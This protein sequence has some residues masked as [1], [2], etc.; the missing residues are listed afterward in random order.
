MLRQCLPHTDKIYG[1][2]YDPKLLHLRII[3]LSFLQPL[4]IKFQDL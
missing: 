1:I 3:R 4:N 2:S